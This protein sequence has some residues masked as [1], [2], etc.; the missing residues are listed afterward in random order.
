MLSALGSTAACTWGL[1]LTALHQTYLSLV[2]PLFLYGCSVCG[3]LYKMRPV[4]TLKYGPRWP[5]SSTGPP[6][7]YQ[8]PSEPHGHRT[9]STTHALTGGEECT[10]SGC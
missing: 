9:L 10:G 1:N 6:G 5:E 2:L 3:T 7:S 8:E 4:I